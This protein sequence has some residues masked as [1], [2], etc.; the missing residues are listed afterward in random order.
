M[1]ARMNPK[2]SIPHERL[3]SFCKKWHVVECALFGS[4]LREDFRPDSDVDILVEFE[5]ESTHS[6]FDLMQMEDELRAMFGR[7]VDLVEK[8]AVEQS[9]N[10]IRRRH[11][12]THAEPLRIA[13]GQNHH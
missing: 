9:Q 13:N 1:V 5:P 11:I 7:E 3:A 10:Y 6:F 4:V 12:L 8:R 2:L